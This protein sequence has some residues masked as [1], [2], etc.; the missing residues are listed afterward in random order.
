VPLPF[1]RVGLPPF[2]PRTRVCR[3]PPARLFPRFTRIPSLARPYHRILNSAGASSSFPFLARPHK[4]LPPSHLLPSPSLRCAS[5]VLP[6]RSTPRPLRRPAPHPPSPA[7]ADTAS[8]G[9]RPRRACGP[10]E[11]SA[12]GFLAARS[13]EPLAIHEEEE[14]AG[15]G[16]R[17]LS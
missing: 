5:A 12:V 1:A 17:C 6:P 16:A 15:R 2:H 14:H 10:T 4:S 11:Q 8:P 7:A 9:Q 13:W 3:P